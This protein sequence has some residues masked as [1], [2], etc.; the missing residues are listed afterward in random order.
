MK[1][2]VI[3]TP[4]PA[5]VLRIQEVPEPG[6]GPGQILARVR[7]TAVNRADLLQRLGKYPPPIG[8][9]EDIPGL[10]FSGV[11][12]EMG[13]GESEFRPGDR[14]MGLLPGEG[15]AEMVVLPESLAVRIPENL[16]WE[17]AASVPEAFLTALDAVTQ[18]SLRKDER[19]LIHAAASGVG[20][21]AIQVAQLL[22]AEVFGTSSSYEK[23]AKLGKLGLDH[24]IN[25]QATSFAEAVLEVTQG[26]GVETILDLVGGCHWD[27][28]VRCLA[29]GGRWLLVGLV[30]GRRVQVDLGQILRKRLRISG[31]VLRSRSLREKADLTEVF[32]REL[33][34]HLASKRIRPVIDR[35]FG[36][37]D[38][39]AAHQYVEENRNT[40]KVVLTVEA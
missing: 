38:V 31:T 4:G 34:P 21:A 40:G 18:L 9:R 7:A 33:L 3:T 24:G 19:V 13:P 11:I 15:Y 16:S 22:G 14:I 39:A 10:E 8:V 5:S 1:A 32:R 35:V 12:E 28:N 37:E 36:L 25:Y 27:G 2:A 29:E 20:T 23:L 17:E 6:F 30:G 26:Q